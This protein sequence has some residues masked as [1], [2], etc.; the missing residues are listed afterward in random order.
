M[1]P[2]E[3]CEAAILLKICSAAS[4]SKALHQLLVH[5]QC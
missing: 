5:I 4:L 3:L 1:L 2:E